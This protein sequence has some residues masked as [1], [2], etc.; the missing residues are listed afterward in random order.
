MQL[1]GVFRAGREG[2]PPSRLSG[3]VHSVNRMKNKP[4]AFPTLRTLYSFK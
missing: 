2:G 1:N 4:A 3:Y